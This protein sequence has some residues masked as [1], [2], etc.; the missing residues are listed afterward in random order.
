MTSFSRSDL[1]D[2]H[3]FLIIARRRNFG[4][5]ANELGL[6]TSALSHAM[7]R[8][9]E[10]LGVRL[11]HRT[12]R[13]VLP[14]SAG[15]VLARRLEDGFDT[16]ADALGELEEYRANP[17]GELKINVPRDAARLLV[18]PVL[19]EFVANYPQ[20]R[21]TLS[22]EDRPIDIVAEGFDMGIRYGGTVPRDMVAVPLTKPL[23]W[24]V[25]AS[26]D[27]LEQNGRP[28]YP[29]DLLEQSCIRVRVG[30]NSVFP[31]ELGEGDAMVRL[32]VSGPVAINETD[33]TIDAVRR[34]VGFGYVLERRALEEVALGTAEI[35]LPDW[36]SPGPAFYA[37][38]SSRR[39]TDPGLRQLIAMIRQREELDAVERK[40]SVWVHLLD[41][42]GPE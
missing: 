11:L 31:W 15:E 6:T 22:C 41:N 40:A 26:P 17:I 13:T 34:G 20:L 4:Q 8:L 23:R 42:D 18:G 35:V 9:E 39:Q 3:V 12:N 36:A 37:Y 10:R 19:P 14:T 38:F 25:I 1:R 27:Y 16:I 33:A 5:A 2:L 32:D 21:L 24:V 30:D 28:V 29:R 7:R